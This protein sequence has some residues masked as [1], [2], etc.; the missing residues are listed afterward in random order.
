MLFRSHRQGGNDTNFAFK[1]NQGRRGRRLALKRRHYQLSRKWNRQA[2]GR[3]TGVLGARTAPKKNGGWRR[4]KD[5]TWER[6]GDCWT[7]VVDGDGAGK[8]GGGF[9]LK[10][11]AVLY[12]C[13]FLCAAGLRL[14][15]PSLKRREHIGSR[16]SLEREERRGGEGEGDRAME[17]LR[18]DG[19]PST[20][21]LV[22]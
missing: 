13:A 14:F 20:F 12:C 3:E 18:S 11:A 8:R 4:R 19:S 17:H 6:E 15:L 16:S 5:E 10:T 7:S 22:T 1:G 2:D 21:F 9:F